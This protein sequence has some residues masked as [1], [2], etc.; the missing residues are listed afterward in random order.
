M[1]SITKQKHGWRVQL[2]VKGRRESAVLPTKAEAQAWALERETVLRRMG[3]SGVNTDKTMQDAFDR[4]AVNVSTKKKTAKAEARRLMA[5]ARHLIDGEP[6]GSFRMC[7][8]TP[9]R[10]GA[11]RDARL[12]TVSGATVIRDLNLLSHV[13]TVA[14]KEWKWVAQSPT[15]DVSRP[16]NGKA[17]DRRISEREIDLICAQLGFTGKPVTNKQQAVAVA[18]LFAIETAMRSG[19]ICKLMPDDIQGRTAIIHDSKNDDRRMVP[20]S[21]RALELIQ[22]LPAKNTLFDI[23]DTHRDALYRKARDGVCDGLNFHDTRHEA[24]TRLARKLDVLDLARMTGHRDIKELLTYY[25]ATAE[26]LA[27][28]LG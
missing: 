20:L 26:E 18:F 6:L 9:E 19:E 14:R 7:D 27:D 4:Y 15:T 28:R 17:R 24:I 16:K 5:L 1:A 8:I 10:L 23:S 25:N 3:K 2:Y 13:F 12:K 11:W 22:L 21:K